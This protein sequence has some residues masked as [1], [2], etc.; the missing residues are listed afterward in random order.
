MLIAKASIGSEHLECAVDM[1]AGISTLP[2]V[3]TQDWCVKAAEAIR[4]VRSGCVVAVTLASLGQR[5]SVVQLESTGAAGTDPFGRALEGEVI[6]PEHAAS[7][8]WW[9]DDSSVVNGQINGHT[10]GLTNGHAPSSAKVAMLRELPAGERW[11]ETSSG[12]RWAKIGVSDLIVAVA[13]MPGS[14]P[15]RSFV[16]EVGVGPNHKPLTEAE[17]NVIRAVMGHLVNRA[18]LAFGSEISTALTRLTQREQQVL[19]HLAL[20]KSVKQ[21]ASDLARSPHTVHDHVKSLHRKLNASSRGELIAR[22]LGH[23]AACNRKQRTSPRREEFTGPTVIA[24]MPTLMT[25]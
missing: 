11:A 14:I 23:L 10:S 8:D 15:G 7:F 12:R 13:A 9:I 2:A 20:G 24:K 16:V 19:E 25:A 1:A 18:T 5:G 21:I 4:K 3:A 17:A 6:H 22:A